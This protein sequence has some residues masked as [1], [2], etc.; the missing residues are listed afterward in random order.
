M[1]IKILAVSGSTRAGSLNRLLLE[2]AASGARSAGASVTSVALAD[3]PL[4]LYD[5][6][7]EAEHGLPHEAEALQSLVATH[8]GLVIA[9]PEYNGGYTAVLK[10]AIDWISRPR[11]DGS[12]G[13]AAF[14]GKLAAVLSASPGALGGTRSQ[15]ALKMVLDKL[16]VTVIPQ[17]FALG[18]AHRAFDSEGALVDK[19]VADLVAL[20]GSSLVRAA[21]VY[22]TP[23]GQEGSRVAA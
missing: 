14:A 12:M 21:A 2:V 9:T 4:P 10:N 6:D 22:A 3:F 23:G 8:H 18:A 16:G 19:K 15:I 1:T 20:V 7:F 11:A 17:S 5:A 13:L